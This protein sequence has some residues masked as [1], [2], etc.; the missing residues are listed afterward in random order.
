M[1][2]NY[3]IKT[4]KCKTCGHKPEGVHIGKSSGGWRFCFNLNGKKYYKNIGELKEWLKNIKIENEYGEEVEYEYF[5][6]LVEEKQ[7]ENAEEEV[8]T[9]SIDGYR[10]LDCEFS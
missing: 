2:T 4:E 3:Y 9:F 5:W 8:H 7:K 10:F 1:G 6:S